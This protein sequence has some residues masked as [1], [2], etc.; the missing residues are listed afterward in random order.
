M[1][2]EEESVK[3]STSEDAKVFAKVRRLAFF[4]VGDTL[5]LGAS[6]ILAYFLRFGVQGKLPLH[7]LSIVPLTWALSIATKVPFLYRQHAYNLSW[8][9]VGIED[10]WGVFKGLSYG[11]LALVALTILFRF[12]EYLPDIPF[13]VLALDYVLSLAA[14]IGFRVSLP[15][16]LFI[17]RRKPRMDNAT[18]VVGAGEMGEQVVRSLLVSKVADYYPVAFVDDDPARSG[19]TIHGVPV[20]GKITDLPLLVKKYG[21]A[22]VIVALPSASSSATH[23]AIEAAR[24]VGIANVRIF[25]EMSAL[26]DR[27][28]AIGDL[29]RVSLEDLLG[30]EVVSINTHEVEESLLGKRVLVTGAAGS[31]GS[32]LCRKILQF[33]PSHLVL[34]DHEETNLFSVHRQLQSE[35]IR[36]D[37]DIIPMLA[38]IRDRKRVISIFKTMQPEVVFHAAAYKHVGMLERDPQEGLRTN[39]LGTA[40]LAEEALASKVERFVLI[41]TDKAVRPTSVMGAT[42]R[43]AEQLCLALNS[44]GRTRFMVVRFGNVLGSRGSVVPIFEEQIQRG[45]PVTVRGHNTRRYFMVV[46]EAVLL[47][48]QAGASGIGGEVFVIEMGDP[49]KIADLAKAMI[50]LHGYEPDKDMKITYFELE[51]GEKEFEEI[52]ASEEGVMGHVHERIL[53]AR[54]TQLILPAQYHDTIKRVEE[55]AE[56]GNGVEVRHLLHSLVPTYEPSLEL[57]LLP[58]V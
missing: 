14:V 15:A 6:V 7:F 36:H 5:L 25:P 4:I 47:V 52:L 3:L 19:M 51:P 17:T 12:S 54:M 27:P 49:V 11:S 23:R 41:S 39:V 37:T 10:L 31:I 58:R 45:G 50:R 21:A 48:L 38:D 46:S 28:A 32:E 40:I 20:R 2:L 18:I 55:I 8:S 57:D 9:F 53:L 29:R 30:R 34:L 42:K 24:T 35:G 26:L 16:W 56:A 22:K 13:V 1:F 33:N 44:Q 43:V